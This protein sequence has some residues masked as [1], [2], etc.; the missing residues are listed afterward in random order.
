LAFEVGAATQGA[1]CSEPAHLSTESLIGGPPEDIGP[2]QGYPSSASC[3]GLAL[4]GGECDK[5]H[6][7]WNT[8]SRR[9]GWWRR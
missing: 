1:I 9:F 8:V 6:I 5:V 3:M 4:S 7:F 2:V